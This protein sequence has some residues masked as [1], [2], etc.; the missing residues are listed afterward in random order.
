MTHTHIYTHI[1]IYIAVLRR[2]GVGQMHGY[3]LVK[4]NKKVVQRDIS[5]DIYGLE[6][7]NT[8]GITSICSDIM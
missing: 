7:G 6:D 4:D 5:L 3:D 1:Y 2:N 8:R